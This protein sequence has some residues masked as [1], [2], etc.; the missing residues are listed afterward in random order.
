MSKTYRNYVAAMTMAATIFQLNNVIRFAL[1]ISGSGIAASLYGVTY[2]MGLVS[3]FFFETF[4]L[5]LFCRHQ[6]WIRGRLFLILRITGIM[7]GLVGIIPTIFVWHLG[8]NYYTSPQ[9]FR[10]LQAACSL[11]MVGYIF[12]YQLVHKILII[13]FIRKMTQTKIEHSE[14][15]QTMDLSLL[16]RLLTVI[17]SSDLIA[18]VLFVTAYSIK[19]KDPDLYQ[20]LMFLSTGIPCIHLIMSILFYV[21][22]IKVQF[23]RELEAK[24]KV[25]LLK[26]EKIRKKSLAVETMRENE[27]IKLTPA[28]H[29]HSTL[30]S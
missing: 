22:M 20:Y 10:F 28:K 2:S 13:Y 9:W 14:G 17:T 26:K 7:M 4:I 21:E 23:S 11:T 15:S 18:A 25:Q 6:N 1:N 24:H 27:T 3:H 16:M 5:E 30:R 12:G 8:D 19:S 29:D